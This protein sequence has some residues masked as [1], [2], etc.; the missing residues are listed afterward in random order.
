MV[1]QEYALFPWMTVAQNIAFGLEVQKIAQRHHPDGESAAGFT[2][3]EDFRDRYPKDL[4]GGMRQRWR[5]PACW[6]WIRRSC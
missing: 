6:R 4:S 5:L 2:A 1:F 3:P